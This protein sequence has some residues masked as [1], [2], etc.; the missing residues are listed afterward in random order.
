MRC[1]EG[2]RGWEAGV[3]CTEYGRHDAHARVLFGCIWAA[4][5]D[6]V[7]GRE[8]GRDEFGGGAFWRH[9][10]LMRRVFDDL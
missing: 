6:F 3:V 2:G 8:A 5:A 1:E 7:K 10:W 4:D 9:F